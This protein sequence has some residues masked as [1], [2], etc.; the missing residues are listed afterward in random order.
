MLIWREES[1]GRYEERIVKEMMERLDP[2][3]VINLQFTILTSS[4]FFARPL[5]A[6]VTVGQRDDR[7]LLRYGRLPD[8][9]AG[10]S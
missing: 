7:K 5:I 6:Y 3:R 2:D 1:G 4:F 8:V 10:A 9:F